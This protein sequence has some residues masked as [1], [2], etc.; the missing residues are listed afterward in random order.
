[1]GPFSLETA[2]KEYEKK[3]KDKSGHKWED[4]SEPA[5]KGKYTFI[6]KSYEDS[7]DEESAVKKEEED[8]GGD[9]EIESKLPKQTQR[10]IELIFNQ[11]H[12]NSVLEG[13]GYNKDKLPLGKLSKATLKQG[14][15]HLNELA[16]LIKHPKLAGDKYQVSQQEVSLYMRLLCLCSIASMFLF[17]FR[18]AFLI[19]QCARP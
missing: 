16:S 14:F 17:C 9:E 10:L 4:R 11:N 12:F 19:R 13:I 2:M 15:E 6:E 18:P 7:D 5:K 3:F 1:M 8:D